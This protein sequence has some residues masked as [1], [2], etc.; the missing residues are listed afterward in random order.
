MAGYVPNESKALLL[1][2]ISGKTSMSSTTVYLGL[3]LDLPADPTTATLSTILEVITA[4]YRRVTVPVFD[5]ASTVSPIQ[6]L[7]S[8]PFSFPALTADMTDAANFA[9][10]TDASSGIVGKIRYVWELP[11]AIQGRNGESISV[12]ANA[13]IIE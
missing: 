5:S 7:V 4:G 2:A 9:F 10:L 12:P 13:L 11:T 3:A 8:S 1:E 6:I